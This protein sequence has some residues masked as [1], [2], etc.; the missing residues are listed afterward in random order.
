MYSLLFLLITSVPPITEDIPQTAFATTK[1]VAI[2]DAGTAYCNIMYKW[3]I[4]KTR[5]CCT[6]QRELTLVIAPDGARSW[7]QPLDGSTDT[8][9]TAVSNDGHHVVGRS[10]LPKGRSIVHTLWTDGRPAIA[11]GAI[12][13]VS[14]YGYTVNGI[15]VTFDGT[16]Y[17]PPSCRRVMALND[18]GNG[19][20]YK[21][22]VPGSDDPG[23]RGVAR[24]TDG[25][26]EDNRHIPVW[27]PI[28]QNIKAAAINN[29]GDML[30][31]VGLD[32]TNTYIEYSDGQLMILPLFMSDINDDGVYVGETQADGTILG[33]SNDG[34]MVGFYGYDGLLVK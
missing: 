23:V 27:L 29:N 17:S 31:S 26:S 14:N 6:Y 22:L 24:F 21:D 7:L 16:V 8:R 3:T 18:Y 34:A 9:V 4:R 11:G 13:A 19:L 30:V 12:D 2:D 25:E 10:F 1:C 28:D 5:F 32:W 20:C 33:I 15:A